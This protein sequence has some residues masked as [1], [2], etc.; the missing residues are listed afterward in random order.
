MARVTTGTLQTAPRV[1]ARRPI[2]GVSDV[3][4]TCGDIEILPR[5]D[6]TLSPSE[7]PR[8]RC[9]ARRTVGNGTSRC[10]PD[11]KSLIQ[12]RLVRID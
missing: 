8:V 10:P 9:P 12:S 2:V 4:W 11:A 7:E 6:V 5:D 1:T 3:S